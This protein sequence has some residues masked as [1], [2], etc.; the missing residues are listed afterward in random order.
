MGPADH[1]LRASGGIFDFH[2]I[3]FD[4]VPFYQLFAA[5]ALVGRQQGFRVLAVRG[6]ADRDTAVARLHMG[7]DTRKNLMLLGGEFLIDQTAFGLADSLNDYL[8]GCLSCNPPEL[9]GFHRDR[10]GITDFRTF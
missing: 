3:N 10:H 9:L 4:T 7:D 2:Y 8:F 5:Y 1:N 6:N